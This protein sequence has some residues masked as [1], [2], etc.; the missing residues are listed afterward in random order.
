VL[1]PF[2]LSPS[3]VATSSSRKPRCPP[4]V[5]CSRISVFAKRVSIS[6]A[7]AVSN[8]C[9]CGRT[10]SAAPPKSL[11]AGTVNGSGSKKRHASSPVAVLQSDGYWTS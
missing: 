5:T 7:S 8:G 4:I 9:S 10:S 11:S 3:P 6:P 1:V 2:E